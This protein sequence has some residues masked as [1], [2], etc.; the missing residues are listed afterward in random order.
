[1]AP[2]SIARIALKCL[3]RLLI[4]GF[5]SFSQD[6]H[7]IDLL[8]F[9]SRHFPP[10]LKVREPLVSPNP[11]PLVK[12]M[13]SFIKLVGKILV[14]AT[15]ERVID[16]CLVPSCIFLTKF[17]WSLLESSVGL[18]Y[19]DGFTDFLMQSIQIQSIVILKNL[20]RHREFGLI[21]ESKVSI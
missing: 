2:L 3:R 19:R 18:V 13:D 6:K 12:L 14:D 16:F 1:M 15:Q 10:F 21:N 7:C 8:N 5:D 20:V 17:Y 9:L 11:S 4:H